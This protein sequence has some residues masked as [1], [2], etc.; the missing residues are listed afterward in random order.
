MNSTNFQLT[1]GDKAKA[2]CP[3]QGTCVQCGYI[4]SQEVKRNVYSHRI[5]HWYFSKNPNPRFARPACSWPVWTKGCHSW[6]SARVA[7][8]GK[9]WWLRCGDVDGDGVVIM[10]QIVQEDT[11]WPWDGRTYSEKRGSWPPSPFPN[12]LL[13]KT[14]KADLCLYDFFHRV[15]QNTCTCS[16][17]WTCLFFREECIVAYNGWRQRGDFLPS[18]LSRTSIVLSDWKISINTDLLFYW[19]DG[20]GPHKTVQVSM[21]PI[22]LH[23]THL[24]HC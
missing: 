21:A 12:L 23:K 2:R 17:A 19:S 15:L 24:L 6:G 4:S 1:V 5:T 13:T 14:K 22:R 9:W 11:C 16:N 8:I 20:H 7:S 18:G 10:I 3:D